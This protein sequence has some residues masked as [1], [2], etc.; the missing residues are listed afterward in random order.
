MS[1]PLPII[2]LMTHPEQERWFRAMHAAGF[3][4]WHGG[5]TV[6]SQWAAFDTPRC[7]ESP[8]MTITPDGTL[9]ARPLYDRIIL[10]NRIPMNSIDHFVSYAKRYREQWIID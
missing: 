8:V 6:D 1:R 5:Q 9:S 3:V 10:H 4:Y 2:C 7:E